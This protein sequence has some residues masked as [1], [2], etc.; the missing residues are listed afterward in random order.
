M[1]VGAWGEQPELGLDRAFRDRALGHRHLGEGRGRQ[2]ALVAAAKKE[3]TLNVIAL[4]TNWA[5]YGDPELSTFHKLYGIKITQ[6][7]PERH[8]RSGDPGDQDREAVAR[9]AGRR[10]RR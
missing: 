10:R 7:E 1:A 2:A 9:R 3:G 4:P 5:N 8:E 6:R